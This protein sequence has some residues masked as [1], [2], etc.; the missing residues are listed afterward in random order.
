MSVRIKIYDWTQFEV[1][2]VAVDRQTQ[3]L[4][5]SNTKDLK[6]QSA[7]M[8]ADTLNRFNG[9]CVKSEQL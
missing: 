5:I 7:D 4:C 2:L 1:G 9:H 6:G 3:L 8:V